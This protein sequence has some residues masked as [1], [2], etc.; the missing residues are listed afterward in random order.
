MNLPPSQ[1]AQG[2][3]KPHRK[4]EVGAVLGAL[5]RSEA[6]TSVS[7]EFPSVLVM[8]TPNE[9]LGPPNEKLGPRLP[10]TRHCRWGAP[11]SMQLLVSPSQLSET[12]L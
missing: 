6:G 12:T 4:P 3:G 5:R 9:K 11:V 8:A 1:A 2:N 7:R 10:L